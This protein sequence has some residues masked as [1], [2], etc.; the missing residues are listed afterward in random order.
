MSLLVTIF[1]NV[2]PFFMYELI[3]FF[4]FKS[5]VTLRLVHQDSKML[6]KMPPVG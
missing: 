3:Y 1:W 2:N 4:L 5:A 6:C